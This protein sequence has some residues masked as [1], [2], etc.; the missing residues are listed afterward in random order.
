MEGATRHSDTGYLA[1]ARRARES[2]RYKHRVDR[3]FHG[4]LR[5]C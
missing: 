5:T 2:Y 4:K 1:Y 3:T